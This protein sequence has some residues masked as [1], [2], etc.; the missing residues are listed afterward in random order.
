[1]SNRLFHFPTSLAAIDND[2]KLSL[3]IRTSLVMEPL[4]LAG[5][6]VISH[7]TGCKLQKTEVLYENLRQTISTRHKL[8]KHHETAVRHVM[9]QYQE[10]WH[11]LQLV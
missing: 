3:E 9:V 7:L 4:V 11:H 5:V 8:D 10:Y 1:M 2:E 6:R